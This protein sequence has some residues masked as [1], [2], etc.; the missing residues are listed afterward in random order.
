M[1]HNSAL[2]SQVVQELS[3]ARAPSVFR[4]S[5]VTRAIKAAVAAGVNI[6]R[7]EIDKSGR[8]VI[9]T[10][11]PGEPEAPAN[12]LDRELAEW[13]ANHGKG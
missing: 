13:E 4:Q 9:V 1:W 12:D 11:K 3:V 8:I 2:N 10:G 6:E 5:D 7:V